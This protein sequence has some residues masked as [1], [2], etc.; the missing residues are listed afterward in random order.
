MPVM[1]GYEATRKLRAEGFTGPIIALTA[2]AM[3]GDRQR[4]LEAGCDDYISKP[5]E[6]ASLLKI[7]AQH[8][9]PRFRIP[10]CLVP[11]PS[12]LLLF[13]SLPTAIAVAVAW[14]RQW[15]MVT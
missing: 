10:Q 14:L 5:V 11:N 9:K 4:C 3:A 6:H 1:D 2:H 12:S 15:E 13:F 7:V 8:V